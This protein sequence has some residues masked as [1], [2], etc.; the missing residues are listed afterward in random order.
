MKGGFVQ[1][2]ETTDQAVTRE[3]IEETGVHVQS[4]SLSLIGMY[5]DPTRDKRRHT[6]SA[7]YLARFP[8]G[9]APKAGDDVKD[10]VKMQ[11]TEVE[12]LGPSSFFADHYTILMDYKYRDINTTPDKGSVRGGFHDEKSY[13]RSICTSSYFVAE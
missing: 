2:G 12:E 8:K 7:V 3:L 1:V 9:A 4:S 6:V 13:R 5:D 10:V 11:L